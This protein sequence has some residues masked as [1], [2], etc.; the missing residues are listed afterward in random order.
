MENTIKE[1]TI[2][3]TTTGDCYYLTDE[4]RKVWLKIDRDIKIKF[5]KKTDNV[6]DTEEQNNKVFDINLIDY[7]NL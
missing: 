7:E 3:V 6:L 1:N 2:E 4:K 5:N